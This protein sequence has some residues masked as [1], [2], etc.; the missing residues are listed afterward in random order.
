MIN[1]QYLHKLKFF[2]ENYY[3]IIEM[4]YNDTIIELAP[5][6]SNH[7]EEKTEE[8]NKLSITNVTSKSTSF[9]LVNPKIA[10]IN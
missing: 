9:P 2:Y 10:I 7:R 5:N 1:V 8:K 6:T 3:L 4:S